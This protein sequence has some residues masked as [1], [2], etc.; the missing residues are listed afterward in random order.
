LDYPSAV[1]SDQV[2]LTIGFIGAGGAVLAGVVANSITQWL[3][4]RGQDKR[5]WHE[6][7]AE[8]F[9]EF[10][11]EATI[12]WGCYH[13][14]DGEINAP[15][16]ELQEVEGR[17][18]SAFARLLLLARKE[19][20]ANRVGEVWDALSSLG[21]RRGKTWEEVERS[22]LATTENFM[23]ASRAELGLKRLSRVH[24]FEEWRAERIDLD[25]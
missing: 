3:T 23:D 9:A 18:T 15:D 11:T 13:S 10:Y 6:R 19:D 21:F 8:A 5:R 2:A 22:L 24:D 1:P 7:R 4:F 25:A 12:W 16:D 17:A 14:H 20:T